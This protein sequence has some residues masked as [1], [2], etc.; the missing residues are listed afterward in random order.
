MSIIYPNTFVVVKHNKFKKEHDI[1]KGDIVYIAG[2]Q[3]FPVSKRDPYTQRVKFF[4]QKLIGDFVDDANGFYVFD[5]RSV[6][7]IDP[8]E[9]QRLLEI[10]TTTD[11]ANAPVN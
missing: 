1:S 10:L 11:A 5:P 8:E 4:V 6:K 7:N 2:H 3:A 9:N